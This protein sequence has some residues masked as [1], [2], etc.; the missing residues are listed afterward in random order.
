MPRHIE[1]CGADDAI[2]RALDFVNDSF[3]AMFCGA[4]YEPTELGEFNENDLF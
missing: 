3:D 2:D 1:E 4:D